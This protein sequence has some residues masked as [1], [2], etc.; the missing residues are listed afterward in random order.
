MQDK[1]NQK[2]QLIEEQESEKFKTKEPT[3]NKEKSLPK[4]VKKL[5][6]N[7]HELERVLGDGACGMRCFDKH[8]FGD[9]SLG[10]QL[11][12]QLNKEIADNFWHYKQLLE[13]P[14]DR[15]EGGSEA[16][17]FENNEEDK[18]LDFLRNHPRNG[19]V[20]RGF[21]DLQALSNKYGMP[22]QII[23]ITDVERIEPDG[24]FEVKEHI[25]E[26]ILLNT[27]KVH[28]DLIMKKKQ[29]DRTK[30]NGKPQNVT[31]I[32]K[33][34]YE[35]AN[36]KKEIRDLKELVEQLL[37][38]NRKEVQTTAT[39]KT[40]NTNETVANNICDECGKQYANIYN[41]EAHVRQE[42]SEIHAFEC[43]TCKKVFSTS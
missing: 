9:A 26:M 4:S 43:K 12:E 32:E 1:I 19:F 15:P 21:L 33:L 13:Y 11:G 30:D 7:D 36:S 23:L 27:G 34:R 41:L 25:E 38:G 20:L 22:I 42:H 29:S 40:S 39:D 18:L 5:V 28:F 6:G 37:P 14:Y 2:S 31:E 8:A 17:K 35:L 10:P 3:V 16:V 24:D